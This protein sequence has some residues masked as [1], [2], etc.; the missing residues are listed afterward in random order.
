MLSLIFFFKSWKIIP[1]IS[2]FL[3]PAAQNVQELIYPFILCYK[4][5]EWKIKMFLQSTKEYFLYKQ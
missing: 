4:S 2:S 5:V 3:K 1:G